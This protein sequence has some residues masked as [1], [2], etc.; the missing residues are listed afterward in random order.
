MYQTIAK[1]RDRNNNGQ[2]QLTYELIYIWYQ[3]YPEL[4]KQAVDLLVLEPN[5]KSQLGSW[6]DIK[7]LCNYFKEQCGSEYH[8]MIS[9]CIQITNYQ[10]WLDSTE[11]TTRQLSLAAKWIPREKSKYKWLFHR[12]V[13]DYFSPYYAK[14]TTT[15]SLKKAHTKAKMNYRK[16]IANLNRRLDTVQIR[17]CANVWDTIDPHKVTMAT[18]QNQHRA[19]L[20]ENNCIKDDRIK[21]AKRFELF[22]NPTIYKPKSKSNYEPF[23]DAIS[24]A[25]LRK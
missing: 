25:F 2:Y 21:C 9:H 19:F 24:E 23:A 11:P 16:L 17:Q 13:K 7:Y 4:A 3:S 22:A 20:N 10:L 8:P 12:L 15:E 14:A 1:T 6:K 18:L 5:A